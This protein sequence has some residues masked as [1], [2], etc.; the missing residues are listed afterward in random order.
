MKSAGT[1]YDELQKDKYIKRIGK[2]DLG[3]LDW[4]MVSTNVSEKQRLETTAPPIGVATPASSS[5]VPNILCRTYE[6]SNSN[7][8][9]SA[10]EGITLRISGNVSV[11]DENYNQPESA[12]DFKAAMSGVMLYYELADQVETPISPELNLTYRCDDFGTEMLLPQNDD[13]P[14]TAPMDCDIVYQLDYEADVRNMGQNM[15]SKE[16][17]GSFIAAFN[18]SG[19]GTITQTWDATNKKYT[20]TVAPPTP[21]PTEV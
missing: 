15:I 19:L 9:F 1:V 6:T 16:S 12:A 10:H 18:S 17:M 4:K 11:Y 21:E 8:T 2:V 14:V 20:Y 13:E 5:I 7:E 3:T